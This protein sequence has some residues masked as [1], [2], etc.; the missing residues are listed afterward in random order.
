MTSTAT[1]S[2]D[3]PHRYEIRLQGRLDA[4]WCALFEGLRLT[5]GDGCTLLEGDVVDQAALHGLLH[6]LRSLAHVVDMHHGRR[7]IAAPGIEHAA[8]RHRGVG[9]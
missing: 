2:P 6:Q 8:A 7:M 4:R 9:P 5:T 3:G 1:S